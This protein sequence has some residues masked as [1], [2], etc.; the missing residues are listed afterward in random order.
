MLAI[1]FMTLDGRTNYLQ[2]VRQAFALPVAGVHYLVHF[3]THVSSRFQ[4]AWQSR[5]TLIARN[6]MLSAQH[7]LLQAELQRLASLEAENVYL[8]ALL[9]SSKAVRG[10]VLIADVLAVDTEPF[11]NQVII[12]KG[13]RDGLYIG[14]PVLDATGV[15]GQIIQVGPVS[16]RLLLINDQKSGVAIQ[17]LRGGLR[18]TAVG[19]GYSGKL[20]LLF[21]PKTADI[22]VNDTFITSGL[23][24]HYPEGYP[25]GRVIFVHKEP[26]GQ[27]ATVYLEPS[28]RLSSSHQVLLVWSSKHA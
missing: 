27:F 4:E 13:R 17:N 21:V 22:K 23:G 9:K 2:F 10:K 14:Q 26:T 6:K 7:F 3:P 24:S 1:V 18:A 25:V 19:D 16:S 11:L 5:D 8:K 12:N 15:M 20:R 28:A